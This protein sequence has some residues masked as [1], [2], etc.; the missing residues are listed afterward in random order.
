MSGER[1]RA[2]TPD[3]D[4]L[5]VQRFLRGDVAAF[6]ILFA[7]YQDYVYHIV[8][9]IIGNAEEA[10]DISQE[11]FVTVYRSL[12]KFRQSARFATW[13]Y[14]IAVNRA[15]D[16]ARG[17]RRWRFL[18]I[19]DV[20]GIG[21]RPADRDDEPDI[22]FERTEERESVQR[23]LMDCPLNHREVL[24]LFYY[25]GLSVEEIADT[26]NCSISATKVRLHRA[27]KVFRDL[28]EASPERKQASERD[29]AQRAVNDAS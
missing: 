4:L 9:G 11:V 29:R 14:R 1:E 18:P 8:F 3:D 20:A 10:R 12:P 24:V 5:I 13:L 22:V 19:M 25:R 26:L 2:A 28:Y 15:V 17:S 21:D 7:R 16:A 27:R 23:I 6:D